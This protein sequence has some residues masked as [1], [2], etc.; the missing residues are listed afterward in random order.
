MSTAMHQLPFTNPIR[1]ANDVAHIGHASIMRA[2][3]MRA[4]IMRA[5]TMRASE[6]A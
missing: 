6:E 5:G 1:F 3:I 2:G 4:D